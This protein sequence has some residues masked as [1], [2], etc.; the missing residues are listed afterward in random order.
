M[1][2][3]VTLRLTGLN[4]LMRSPEAQALV[5]DHGRRIATRAGAD[6]EYVADPHKW[7]ARGFVQPANIRGMREQA[8]N[9]ALERA[10]GG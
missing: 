8:K 3:R 9:A 10:L 2:V 5:D 4:K 1:T 7:T 6:F